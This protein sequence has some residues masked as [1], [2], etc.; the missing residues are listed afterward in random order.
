ML[1]LVMINTEL[2]FLN[3]ICKQDTKQ[4]MYKIFQHKPRLGRTVFKK[5]LLF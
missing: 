4:M 3:K 2:R 5:H 1:E